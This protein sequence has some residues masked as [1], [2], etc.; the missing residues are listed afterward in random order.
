LI[1]FSLSSACTISVESQWAL[2]CS[3]PCWQGEVGWG[4]SSCENLSGSVFSSTYPTPTLP[5]FVPQG[6][7]SCRREGENLALLR[8]DAN[9]GRQRAGEKEQR[10]VEWEKSRDAMPWQEEYGTPVDFDPARSTHP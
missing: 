9:Q 4:W 6:L 7:T 2:L 8:L 10:G 1:L 3:S 5:Y